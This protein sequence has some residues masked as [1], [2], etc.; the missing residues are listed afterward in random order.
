MLAFCHACFTT[1]Y[2]NGLT[3]CTEKGV[4]GDQSPVLGHFALQG[5]LLWDPTQ[6]IPKQAEIYPEFQSSDSSIYLAHFFQDV[7]QQ[8]ITFAAA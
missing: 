5:S 3:L 8:N 7:E 1:A 6:N 2:L 4:H